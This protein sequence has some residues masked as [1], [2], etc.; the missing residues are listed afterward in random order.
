M[1]YDLLKCLAA[2]SPKMSNNLRK[3]IIESTHS[4][5]AL[6]DAEAILFQDPTFKALVGTTQAIDLIGGGVKAYVLPINLS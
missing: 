5:R 4:D 2:H 1:T 3:A 6:E